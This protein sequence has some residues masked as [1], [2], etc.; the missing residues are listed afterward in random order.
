[1]FISSNWRTSDATRAVARARE[2][3]ITSGNFS[4]EDVHGIRRSA[5][6]AYP[7]RWFWHHAAEG[8]GGRAGDPVGDPHRLSPPRHRGVLRQREGGGGGDQ[9]FA[10]A[11]RGDL[12]HHQGARQQSQGR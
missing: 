8:G 3:D 12:P 2:D 5:W 1:I 10:P 7:D 4:L 11:A 6:R 9:G